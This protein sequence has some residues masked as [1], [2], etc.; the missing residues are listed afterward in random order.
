MVC[1]PSSIEAFALTRTLQITMKGVL[2]SKPD[3]VH[4]H[5]KRKK[6]KGVLEVTIFSES[7]Q[8]NVHQNRQGTWLALE[9]EAW[10]EHFK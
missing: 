4:Y 9:I 5:F 6:E 10:Q 8:I 7:L 2:K 3:N 1:S